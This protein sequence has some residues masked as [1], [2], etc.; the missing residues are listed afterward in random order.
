[1]FKKH[2][3]REVREERFSFTCVFSNDAE[4]WAMG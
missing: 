2:E 1:M 3:G 4:A